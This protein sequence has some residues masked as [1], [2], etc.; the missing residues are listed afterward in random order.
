VTRTATSR[1]IVVKTFARVPGAAYQQ[2]SFM[3]SS[4]VSSGT[5]PEPPASVAHIAG[6][7]PPHCTVIGGSPYA[8]FCS[9]PAVT[10]RAGSVR[11]ADG[12]C[13][14]TAR[15]TCAARGASFGAATGTGAAGTAA[16]EVAAAS[17]RSVRSV[18]GMSR[19]T[20]RMPTSTA[21]G[22]ATAVAHN[23]AVRV[24]RSILRG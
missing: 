8:A 10:L 14:V 17:G 24:V 21:T 9:G 4:S 5:H 22:T 12:S 3:M 2:T 15:Q 16:G 11:I 13:D 23:A 6:C 19:T 7:G 18:P 1:S 20:M